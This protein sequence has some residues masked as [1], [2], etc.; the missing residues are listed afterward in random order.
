VTS[1]TSD[2]IPL[3]QGTKPEAIPLSKSSTLQLLAQAP[4]KKPAQQSSVITMKYI[5]H[6]AETHSFFI[7]I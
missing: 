2:L 7:F 5:V 4:N 6:N 3:F 1:V